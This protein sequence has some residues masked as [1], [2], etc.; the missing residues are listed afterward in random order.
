MTPTLYHKNKEDKE[1]KTKKSF[2][3]I[4]FVDATKKFLGNV[5]HLVT[6]GFVIILFFFFSCYSE[7]GDSS[8]AEQY[9]AA[10]VQLIQLKDT[11]M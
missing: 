9:V 5:R 4:K 11:I 7:R 1:K 2:Q 10:H 3:L 6:L 8:E